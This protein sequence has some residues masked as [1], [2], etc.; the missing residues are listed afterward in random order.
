MVVIAVVVAFAAFLLLDWY[1]VRGR[2]REPAGV[3]AVPSPSRL[4]D[5]SSRGPADLM[6]HPGHAWARTANGGLVAAGSDEFAVKFAGDLATIELPAVGSAKRQGDPAWTLISKSGRRLEQVMPLE[7]EIA[8]INR[9]LLEDP[10]L[11]GRAP[12]DRGWIVRIRP[13]HLASATRN[14]LRGGLAKTWMNAVRAT[15][16]GRL[17]PIAQA[18]AADGGEWVDGFGD[19]LD[20]VTWKALRREL[21]PSVDPETR[22]GA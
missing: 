8:E 22:Q 16:T 4:A 17:G 7:G 3:R 20:D 11:A 12:Y 6:F 9:D 15:V 18:T 10:S 13:T 5:E 1:W 19:H 2:H 14:L 21:F